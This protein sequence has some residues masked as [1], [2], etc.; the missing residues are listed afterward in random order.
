MSELSV[1]GIADA[2]ARLRRREFSCVELLTHVLRLADA[3]AAAGAYITRLDAAA[4]EA[5][6]RADADFAAGIDRGPLQGIPIGLKD[7]IGCEGAPTTSASRVDDPSIH[8]TPD[9][10]VVRT[11]RQ[12]AAVI[13]GK[14]MLSELAIGTP[15]ERHG[16]PVP[17][18]PWRLDRWPGG[19]S[20]GTAVAV[21]SGFVL[22]GLGT[23]S[24]GSIRTPAALCGVT[25][26]KPTFGAISFEGIVG[27]APSLDTTGLMARSAA[28]CALLFTALRTAPSRP[29]PPVDTLRIGFVAPGADDEDAYGVAVETFSR[30][31]RSATPVQL[32][33]YP[34]TNAATR[35]VLAAES[36]AGNAELLRTQWVRYSSSTRE[37]LSDGAHISA[38]QL[39]EARRRL[40]ATRQE[41]A[42][43]LRTL[44]VVVLPT[45]ERGATL[46]T[47]D[48]PPALKAPG[49]ASH[50]AYASGLGFPALAVPA[51][52]TSEGMPV[53]VQLL[54]APGAEEV[55]LALGAA[56]EVEAGWLQH[57]PT[58]AAARSGAEG[59]ITPTASPAPA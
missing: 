2:A 41:A 22:G 4:L 26:L 49:T 29:A 9:A 23:D 12:A 18:N 54:G 47:V 46:R 57:R 31:G 45:L 14:L 50:T 5:A 59:G 42:G 55:L 44:D 34:A 16:F 40:Q 58:F 53:S 6:R 38:A 56:Y 36:Y 21:A 7:N 28:D 32:P 13:T 17:R 51:G 10:A 48:D 20:S 8:P 33:A 15:D 52:F 19:S 25:G 43:L 3:H 37:R 24:A 35:V 11:L 27:L 1:A 39:H 30:L